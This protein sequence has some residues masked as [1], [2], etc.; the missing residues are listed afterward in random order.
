MG[1]DSKFALWHQ[2]VQNSF[3]GIGLDV[4]AHAFEKLGYELLLHKNQKTGLLNKK[5]KTNILSCVAYW[6]LCAIFSQSCTFFNLSAM[7]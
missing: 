6:C 4:V 1:L 3:A 7:K 5:K 2:Y